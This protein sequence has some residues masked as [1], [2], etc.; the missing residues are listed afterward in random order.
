MADDVTY[1]STNPAG[2]PDTTKQVTDEHATRGH[3]PVV[4]LAF[5]ADGDATPIPAD[6]DGLLI[7]LGANNDVTITNNVAV[8]AAKAATATLSNVADS[9]TSVTLLASNTN[10][11]GA[12]LFNDSNKLCYVKFGATASSTSFT[13]KMQGDAYYEVPFG[14]TGIIDGIWS[15]NSSGSMRVTEL[16]A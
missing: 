12:T 7:N 2:L 9:A 5:S 6:A 4:K 10:R 3:M 13:V 8:T 16:T 14:Y 1:T 11:L 15:A